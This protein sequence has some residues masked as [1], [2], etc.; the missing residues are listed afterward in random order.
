MSGSKENTAMIASDSQQ[1]SR[2]RDS[3]PLF[4]ICIMIIYDI[5]VSILIMLLYL[6]KTHI[7]FIICDCCLYR[8]FF[9][10]TTPATRS[11][12]AKAAAGR[13]WLRIVSP[14]VRKLLG[15]W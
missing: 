4:Y 6:F 13:K 8:V 11:R 12:S 2:T 1:E 10:S 3:E 5:K 7:M 15:P 9:P 14:V